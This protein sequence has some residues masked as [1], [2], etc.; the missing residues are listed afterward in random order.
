VPGPGPGG[1]RHSSTGMDVPSFAAVADYAHRVADYLLAP[2]AT[3][4]WADWRGFWMA[5]IFDDRFTVVYFLPLV[6]ILLL[7][8][9]QKLRLAI[10]ATCLIFMMYVFG[11][12]YAILWLL[13]CICLFWFSERFAIES[14]RTDVLTIGPPL[15]A[16]GIVGG[17]YVATMLLNDLRLPSPWNAWML[18]HTRWVYPLGVRGGLWEPMLGR[19]RGSAKPDAPVQLFQAMFYNVH[20]IGTAYLA[21]RML[22]YFSE[23]KR[24]TLPRERR[25]L[26]HFLSYTCYAP[27]LI[28][29]PIERFTTFHDEM[30]T[31]HERRTWRNVPP[32]LA[33]IGWGVAK[34]L[35]S[36]W[37]IQPLLWDVYGFGHGN[38][39]YVH[40][41]QITSFWL[42]YLGVFFQIFGLYVEFS[43]Y[44]DV[45]AG[46]ARLL[47]YRQI[48]NF[49]WPWFATSMRDLWRRWHISLSEILRDY[50]YIPLGGGRHKAT[51]NL[52]IT[53]FLCGIWHKLVLQV[54][55]WGL[56]IGL[57]VAINQHWARWMKRL[58]AQPAGT[59]PAIRRGVLKLHPLPRVFSWLITQHAFVF[60]LLIFFGGAGSVR[61]VGE[62]L[63]R[64]WQWAT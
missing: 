13:T 29:G 7:V 41:E 27:A 37:Y 39:Y 23:L 5:R 44:C 60:S 11:V 51:R 2:L 63:R 38:T 36:T 64:V 43:G 19:L 55:L 15:A 49:R 24:D 16:V 50:V 14:K 4:P 56:L 26:L 52:L 25:T 45:A 53:F 58:A 18:A 34:S 33:R 47:G 22:H 57:F 32:A 42:L 62:I 12:A 8:P 30:D 59:L 48:E 1:A 54:A 20:N 17:W 9:H 21:A 31:C 46:I 35:G 6:P 28:Q 10:I 3:T 61:V 40:P